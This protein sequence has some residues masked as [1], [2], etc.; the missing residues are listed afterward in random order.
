MT[1]PQRIAVFYSKGRNFET[2]L[3]AVRHQYP[4]AGV[5]ALVPSDYP[6]SEEERALVNVVEATEEA[7]YSPKHPAA[8]MRLFQ[9]IRAGRYDIFVITFN[10]PKLNI[11]AAASGARTR[12]FCALDGRIRTIYPGFAKTIADIAYRNIRGRLTYA[13]IWLA[14]HCLKAKKR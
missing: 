6:A 7:R 2:V 1:N 11:L 14:V 12:I 8:L 5:T 13:Y 4:Q 9:S 3:K 10:S